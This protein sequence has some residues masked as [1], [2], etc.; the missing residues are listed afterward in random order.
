MADKI[1]LIK[2]GAAISLICLLFLSMFSCLKGPKYIYSED[3]LSNIL[4]ERLTKEELKITPIPFSVNESIKIYANRLTKNMRYDNYKIDSL[5]KAIIKD[6]E[7]NIKY[8]ESKSLTAIEVFV[9]GE[10]NCIAYTNLFIG[11]ARAVG[12]KAFYIDVTQ[13][14]KL[15]KEGEVV[16]NSGHICAGVDVEGKLTLVDFA[17]QPRI[18]YRIYKVIDDFEAMANFANSVGV[19]KSFQ[20]P[21]GF[22]AE[23]FNE[24]IQH[25]LRAIK[26]KPNFAKAHNNL[27]IA[28][29]RRRLYDKAIAQYKRAIQ[30]DPNLS[31]AYNNLGN[32][33]YI[34]GKYDEAIKSFK[35]AIKLNKNNPYSRYD[36]AL[37]YYYRREYQKGITEL[38][39]SIKLEEEYAEAYNLLG[40]IY[41]AVGNKKYAIIS[42]KKALELKPDL[43][44]AK[45]NL[46]KYEEL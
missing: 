28:Y 10:A 45:I 5:I 9:E 37:V 44:Q 27:G 39:K 21:K 30:L 46:K 3:E 17:E 26:I 8:N 22:A 24:D 19:L 6:D 11:M 13:V 23:E 34:I 7:L 42:F 14:R 12:M 20:F 31:A 38:R 16:I 4:K 40:L 1:K 15:R 25:Y 41:Q 2:R 29:Q 33:L 35:K 43:Q 32:A 18:G 36:L